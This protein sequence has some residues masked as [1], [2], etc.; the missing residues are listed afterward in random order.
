MRKVTSRCPTAA[1]SARWVRVGVGVRVRV[2]LRVGVK[3]RVSV[4]VKVRVRG[5]GRVGVQVGVKVGVRVGVG[6]RVSAVRVGVSSV[7]AC[8]TA[9]SS[10]SMPTLLSEMARLG[11]RTTMV[12]W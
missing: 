10:G 3:V 5:R 6:V 12:T 8:R 11:E 4:E 9:A 1:R 7:S 2:G